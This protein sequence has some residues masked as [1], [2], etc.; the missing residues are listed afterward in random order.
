MRAVRTVGPYDCPVAEPIR[1]FIGTDESQEVAQAV[2]R[3][4][5]RARTRATV[6]FTDLRGLA[7]GLEGTFYT[8]FSFYRWAIPKLCQFKG[9]AIYV[10]ADIVFEADIADL[11]NLPLAGHTHLARP[12]PEF[13]QSYTSVMLLDCG[14]LSHWQ[15]DEWVERAKNDRDF[16]KATMWCEAS[17]P[18]RA[19]IGPLPA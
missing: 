2:L 1:V 10:D 19:G 3:H 7:S 17:G 8:G 15:F 4:S 13:D 12:R 11:W 9:R 6:E 16:Y 5:I 14:R 18:T